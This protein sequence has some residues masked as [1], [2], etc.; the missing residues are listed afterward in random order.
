MHDH[1][2]ML[3]QNKRQVVSAIGGNHLLQGRDSQTGLSKSAK[4]HSRWRVIIPMEQ[5]NTSAML[6][7]L[8][9]ILRQ[10]VPRNTFKLL[11]LLK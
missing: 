1:R 11:Q 4:Q 8:L 2:D 6:W 10:E 3:Y 5:Y 7:P 9:K